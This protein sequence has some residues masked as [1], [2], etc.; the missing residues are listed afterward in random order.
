MNTVTVTVTVII[1]NTESC[2]VSTL[3]NKE[4]VYKGITLLPY[5]ESTQTVSI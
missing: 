4:I 3:L 2:N 5:I 1:D